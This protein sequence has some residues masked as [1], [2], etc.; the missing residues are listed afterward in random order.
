[1]R[2]EL[3]RDGSVLDTRTLPVAGVHLDANLTFA[4]AS[5]PGLYEVRATY[6]RDGAVVEVHET[7]FWRRDE[8]V[9]GSGAS[10]T[11]GPTYLR[12][13]GKP[14]IPVG[15]NMW[16]NDTVWAVF[17]EN[18]NALE[19]DR[20]FAEMAA[21]GLT[22]VRTGI[23]HD[24]TRMIDSPTGTAKESVLR[25]IEAMLLAAG[26]HG[27]QVQ[28]TL[29]VFEPQ[30]EMRAS[31]SMLGPGRNP[32]TDPV[33]V[34]AQSSFVRSIAARFKDVPFLSWDLI[35]EPSF[36][37]PRAIFRGNQPNADPTE[38]EA[39][40]AWLRKRHGSAR[41]LAEAWGT[42]PAEIPEIA[43]IA[44]PEPAD[45]AWTRNGNP[46]QVRAVDYNLFAQDVFGEWAAAM[47]RVIRETGS[48][49]I[50]A[51]GQDEG[52]VTNRL[53]NQFYGGSGVDLTS[54]H[55]WWQDDALLWD[56]VAAKRPGMP[57]LLGETGPQPSI[58]MDGES[59]WDETKGLGLVER[60]L[61]LGLA[62]ANGGSAVWIW[63]RTDPFRFGRQDGSS[64]S[65]VDTLGRL[66]A[67]ARDAAPHLSDARPGEVAIVL[68]QSLQLSV[69]NDHAIEAQQKCVRALFHHARA[70]A[71]AVGEHQVGLLGDPRLILLPAPWV[72]SERAW[73]AILD[74]V[75]AGATLLVT[76]RFDQDEYFRPTGRHRAAGLDYT[77]AILPT[78]ENLVRW[79]G[80][81]GWA[82]FSGN[83][84][85][86]LEQATLASGATFASRPVG[87]GQVLFFT[88]PLELNDDLKLLGDVYRWALQEARVT[89]LYRTSVD[90]P[91]ILICPTA[92][93]KATLYVLA[94]ESSVPRDVAFRDT[95]SGKQLRV[96]LDP[97]RAALLLVTHAG[98][99]AARYEPSAAAAPPAGAARST[100]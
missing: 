52:G 92:L 85:T 37:N 76:G 34:E 9:L 39:W 3:R 83:K 47:V 54:L 4:A 81:A 6:E 66:G 61:A 75:H 77:P 59:R 44:L 41:A 19:W 30:S 5:S 45:L 43:G 63:S 8:T 86:Y 17:P 67:F 29:F 80:G 11:A 28:F 89:P 46:K 69:F 22:F 48:R 65:W 21:R 99:V 27:L 36:S 82:S 7:G 16:V 40:N 64:T 93:E 10:L 35:N 14:F 97:G 32:Y 38:V 50:V 2:I 73:S 24:R 84:T 94:S 96:R 20:D 13:D 1:V 72:L 91:G 78:R 100:R 71:Y 88:L 51:V 15:V 98:E 53:L 55:N 62:A 23:W 79:P 25:N 74:K 60:K 95:A 56:A 87:R 58:A 90:D 49:Q 31:V 68:P 26:R 18:A 70:S 12:R 42:I 57:N 33:A